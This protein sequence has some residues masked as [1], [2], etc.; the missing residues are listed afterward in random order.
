MEGIADSTGGPD[1]LTSAARFVCGSLDF[2]PSGF[3]VVTL[4][5][6]CVT[7]NRTLASWA[8]PHASAEALSGA[9]LFEDD[10]GTL[11][12]ALWRAAFGE[13]VVLE[14]EQAPLIQRAGTWRL[15]VMPLQL[16]A[17]ICGATIAFENHAEK[18]AA[19]ALGASAKQV[20]CLLDRASHGVAVHSGNVLLYVNSTAARMLLYDSVDEMVGRPVFDF[21]H[22][23][24][25]ESVRARLKELQQMGALPLR[26]QRFVRKDGSVVCV[27]VAACRAPL[28]DMVANFV[29]FRDVAHNGRLEPVAPHLPEAAEAESAAARD[30]SIDVSPTVLICDD[31]ARLARLTAE[32]LEQRGYAVFAVVT[33][34]QALDTL[35][36]APSIGALLLDINVSTACAETVLDRMH[37]SGL[38]VPVVLTSGHAE[39]D[40]PGSLMSDSLVSSYLAKPYAVEDLV[41]AV[42]EALAVRAT[43]HASGKR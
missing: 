30:A 12:C 14:L 34:E 33:A 8:R 25:Q 18:A 38:S 21:V 35:K 16:G 6:T 43:A 13:S 1:A 24:S 41:A 2:A 9:S 10:D 42:R 5:G 31:E 19:P 36:A 3:A 39:E 37:A 28:D 7:V 29:F 11:R 40:V 26:E 4:D 27:E 20:R 23:D 17:R 15:H 22:P 32:L